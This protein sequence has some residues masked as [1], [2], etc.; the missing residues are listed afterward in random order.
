MFEHDNTLTHSNGRYFLGFWGRQVKETS[1]YLYPL[2][3]RTL[4]FLYGPL[5]SNLGHPQLGISL[6]A[7]VHVRTMIVV[8]ITVARAIHCDDWTSWYWCSLHLDQESLV[9][10]RILREKVFVRSTLINVSDISRIS[11][12]RIY[13]KTPLPSVLDTVRESIPRVLW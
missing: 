11:R 6:W 13:I 7:G 2:T 8:T 3:W 4:C 12:V 9:V 10:C 5:R 1:S